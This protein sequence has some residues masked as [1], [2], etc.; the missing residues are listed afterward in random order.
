MVQD[1]DGRWNS[2]KSNWGEIFLV[3]ED[4]HQVKCPLCKDCQQNPDYEKIHSAIVD[5]NSQA[6]SPATKSEIKFKG[7]P[8]FHF[9]EFH[10]ELAKQLNTPD[11]TYAD[12]LVKI[13][14]EKKVLLNGGQAPHIA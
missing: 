12:N 5:P 4:G 1:T 11:S 6:A 14:K 3:Y 8:I 10:K 2:F 13:L 7:S 9:N